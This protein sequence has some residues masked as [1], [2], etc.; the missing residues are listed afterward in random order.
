[1]YGSCL[2]E[3]GELKQG[4]EE[5]RKA[6]A[7]LSDNDV[8]LVNM[9]TAY[10]L[11]G[12]NEQ[13]Q[14]KYKKFL[15]LYPGHS[16]AEAVKNDLKMLEIEIMRSKGAVSSKGQDNYLDET[17]TMGAGR[18]SAAQM[19]LPV[20]IDSGAEV[21]DYRDEFGDVLKQ[22]FLTWA[23][24]SGGKLSFQFVSK[25]EEA[26][27]KCA[28]TAN[29]K[30]LAN[31]S[32][33]G[34]AEPFLGSNGIIQNCQILIITKSPRRKEESSKEYMAH[35]CLHEVGHCIGLLGHSGQPGDIMFAVFPSTPSGELT[36][37][38]K[39]TLVGLYNASD[40]TIASHP[41]RLDKFG[42]LSGNTANP[43]E[44]AVKLN[45]EGGADLESGNYQRAISKFEE[46]LKLS[47]G[48]EL[49]CMNLGNTYAY[50][51]F[52]QLGSGDKVSA[53]KSFNLSAD[54]FKRAKRKDLAA[55]AYS[56]L[57]EMAEITGQADSVS[58][59]QQLKKA[60]E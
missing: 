49:L 7:I 42:A 17:M 10:R 53:E 19:P 60:V 3:L 37:R 55:K 9:A 8:V 54:Y 22:A 20:F 2:L 31:P 45:A 12:Q 26:L 16:R 27:I 47:P 36:D 41:M 39:N 50:V 13:A 44:K 4:L 24:A 58:K 1:M 56:K 46:A 23:D 35:V 51:G 14:E 5:L 52:Q 25:P 18:W 11:L 33:G 38:D 34:Q 30:D 32:E 29:V 6:D 48:T 43:I 40:D 28:W 21:K 57:I 59:Y 15:K